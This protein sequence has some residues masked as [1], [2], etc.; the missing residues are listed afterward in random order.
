MARKTTTP[1]AA[2]SPANSARPHSGG[3]Q[4]SGMPG[5]SSSERSESLSDSTCTRAPPPCQWTQGS[6]GSAGS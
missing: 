5:S 3:S 2:P 1:A 6:G 4:S